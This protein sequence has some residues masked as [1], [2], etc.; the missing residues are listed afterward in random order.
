MELSKGDKRIARTIIEK[1]LMKEFAEGLN[2]ADKILNDWKQ[3]KGDVRESYHALFK[4]IS[5]FDKGIARRYDG[6]RNSVLIFV[7]LQQLNEKLI[8]EQELQAFSADGQELIQ[9]ILSFRDM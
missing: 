4:H 3:G 8:E 7:V 1:G 6:M 5:D 9:R 2:K